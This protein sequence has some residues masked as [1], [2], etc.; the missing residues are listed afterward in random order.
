MDERGIGPEAAPEGAASDLQVFFRLAELWK[1]TTDQQI[2]LLGSPARSTF[3]KWK[4]EGGALPADTVERISH[5]VALYKSLEILLPR[6]EA[7]E[8]WI[9]RP[10]DYFDGKSALDVMLGGRV[11]NLFEVRSYADA[12]RGG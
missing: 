3:F 11:A 10:N 9:H 4:K 7:A 6:P 5:L 2:S 1:L 12:Q 8:G